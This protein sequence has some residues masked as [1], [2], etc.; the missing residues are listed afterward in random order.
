MEF[1]QI[2]IVKVICKR[3]HL[4]VKSL[5]ASLVPANQEDRRAAWI[6]GEKWFPKDVGRCKAR[7]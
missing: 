3:N 4:L 5:V 7:K 1:L 6:K 2:H